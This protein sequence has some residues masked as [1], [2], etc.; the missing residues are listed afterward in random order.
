MQKLSAVKTLKPVGGVARVR[1]VPVGGEGIE[2]PL[3]E[4]RSS[5]DEEILCDDGLL[6]VCHRLT[7]VLPR[8]AV[9]GLMPCVAKLATEGASALVVTRGARS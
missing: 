7:L 8:E 3:V 5:Y 9:A 1:L 4:E 2:M 6:R